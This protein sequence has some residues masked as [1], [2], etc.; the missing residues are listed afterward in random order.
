[1]P[2]TNS[3]Q[4]S[5]RI[6]E[7]LLEYEQPLIGAAQGPDGTTFIAV[8]YGPDREDGAQDFVF[9]CADQQ[10][11]ADFISGRIDLLALMKASSA[12]FYLGAGYGGADTTITG[13]AVDSIPEAAKPTSGLVLP[14]EVVHVLSTR[15]SALPA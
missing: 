7:V 15:Y 8:A 9:V 1:M 4:I 12:P 13:R 5:L 3:A 11:V 14:P 2:T 6:T 10:Q